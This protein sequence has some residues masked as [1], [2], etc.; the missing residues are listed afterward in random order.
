MKILIIRTTPNLVNLNTY[1][2]QE[3]GLAKALARK[4]HDCDVMYYCDKKKDYF[5]EITIDTNK[6]IGV[7]WIH[8]FGAFYEGIYPSLKKY[9]N[10]YDIIQ[11]GGYIGITSLW[12]NTHVQ[13][14]TVN[15]QGPYYFSGNT[16]D[17]R[18]ARIWDCLLLPFSNKDKMIVATKSILA[19]QY[20]KKKGIGD[21][22]T[23]GVGLDLDNL[24][25]DVDQLYKCKFIQKLRDEKMNNKY[26]LY[27]GVL[28]ERRNILFL[29]KTIRKVVDRTPQIKFI[30]I[31]KG[32]KEYVDLCFSLIKELN[33]EGKVVYKDQLEQK[34]MRAVY[35]LSDMFLFPTRYEIFGMVLLEA[36]YFGLPVITTYNG[37]SSTLINHE[38]GVIIRTLDSKEWENRIIELLENTEVRKCIG[39]KAHKTISEEYTWDALADKFIEVYERRLKCP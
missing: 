21:V 11:V 30:L 6:K 19:T 10:Q 24:L 23:I 31:G 3:I 8:G 15:Y 9:V 17:I 12:L 22:T 26:L 37:G 28:E 39:E 5:E 36:M 1:N 35:E 32:K 38:N 29:I 27:I 16:G 18:K 4:G 34:Y 14:K 20:I 33:L 7:L 13:N 2:L 25:K